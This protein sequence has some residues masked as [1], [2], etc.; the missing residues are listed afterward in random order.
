MVLK[1][2]KKVLSTN[3]TSDSKKPVASIQLHSVPLPRY[4]EFSGE[5][6]KSNNKKEICGFLR[7]WYEKVFNEFP[8]W[9]KQPLELI[10][11][12][13]AYELISRDY[14]Q[15]RKVMPARVQQNYEAARDFNIKGF[16][17]NMRDLVEVQ[18]KYDDEGS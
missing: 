14:E 18:L 4:Y 12:K 1:K 2:K 17:K 11:L 5:F 9:D 10:K 6:M 16:S 15:T 3:S 8:P 7:T 13:I